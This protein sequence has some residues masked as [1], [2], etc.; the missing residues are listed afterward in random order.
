[1]SEKSQRKE[2]WTHAGIVSVLAQ[3]AVTNYHRLSDLNNSYF[4]QF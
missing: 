4:S 2:Y 3:A 1:M